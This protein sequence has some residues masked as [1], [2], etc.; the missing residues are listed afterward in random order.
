MAEARP[1]AETRPTGDR[2][3]APEREPGSATT[4]PAR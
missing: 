2:S 3:A 4:A 1:T